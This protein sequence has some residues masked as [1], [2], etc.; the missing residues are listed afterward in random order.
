MDPCIVLDR[1]NG[2]FLFGR[3]YAKN[4][5]WGERV[6]TADGRPIVVPNMGAVARGQYAS[7]RP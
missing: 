7:A 2:R 3:Q 4:V 6:S 1:T 5:T